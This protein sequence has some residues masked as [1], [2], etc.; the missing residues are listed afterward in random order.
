MQAKFSFDR[1]NIKC[2]IMV[3]RDF[4]KIDYC[5]RTWEFRRE[6]MLQIRNHGKKNIWSLIRAQWQEGQMC[7]TLIVVC[8]HSGVL[9]WEV[10]FSDLLSRR[11]LTSK[12]AEKNVII[13]GAST[14]FVW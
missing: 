11:L 10:Q 2:Y 3:L 7:S 9:A 5:F 4:K 8:V 12:S 14:D 13:L 1:L 6:P